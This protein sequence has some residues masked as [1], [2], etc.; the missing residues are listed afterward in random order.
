MRYII[1]ADGTRIE[2]L[3]D[4]T[5]VNDIWAIRSSYEEAAGVRKL[6]N[7][8]NASVIQVYTEGGDMVDRAANLILKEGCIVSETSEG[9]FECH[10]ETRLKDRF[11][12]IQDQLSEI[13]DVILE[14]I[15]G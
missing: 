8:D 12:I 4:D 1:L 9:V 11:D 10:I 15:G 6:F 13:Q 3:R 2:N 14:L 5:T 7:K